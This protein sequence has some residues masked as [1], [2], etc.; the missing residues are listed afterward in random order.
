MQTKQ[1][2][3]RHDN[4]DETNEINDAVHT[5]LLSTSKNRTFDLPGT[6]SHPIRF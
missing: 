4:D 5:D 2:E 1:T 3:H 6:A